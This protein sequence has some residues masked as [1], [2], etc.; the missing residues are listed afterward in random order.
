MENQEL[1]KFDVIELTALRHA[2]IRYKKD[3]KD[4]GA[5]FT[6]EIMSRWEAWIN[7]AI[8]DAGFESDVVPS[9]D[10]P[11]IGSDGNLYVK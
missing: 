11:I 2:V 10:T 1:N 8:S 4:A 3:T 6:S 5:D 9:N 7:S